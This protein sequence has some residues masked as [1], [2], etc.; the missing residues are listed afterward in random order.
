MTHLHP[1][2]TN[3]LANST[4]PMPTLEGVEDVKT[5]S[6]GAFPKVEDT[7]VSFFLGTVSD[8]SL[9]DRPVHIEQSDLFQQLAKANNTETISTIF[10]EIE[11]LCLMASKQKDSAYDEFSFFSRVFA[12][13]IKTASQKTKAFLSIQDFQRMSQLFP[14]NKLFQTMIGLYYTGVIHNSIDVNCFCTEQPPLLRLKMHQ[15]FVPTAQDVVDIAKALQSHKTLKKLDIHRKQIGS[16]GISVIAQALSNPRQQNT[17]LTSLNLSSN[18]GRQRSHE[19]DSM[20]ELVYVIKKNKT[21]TKLDL[22]GNQINSKTMDALV[23]ALKKNKTLK[24]LILAQNDINR[25]KSDDIFSNGFSPSF[26][27]ALSSHPTLTELN[28]S[29]NRM[30]Y[31][32][33]QAIATIMK[34][35]K[36]LIR[37][38]LGINQAGNDGAKKIAKALKQNST[39]TSLTLKWNRIGAEGIKAIAEALKY[40]ETL[41]ELD[42]EDN[43][44]GV[45]GSK[46]LAEALT[47]NKTLKHINL[48]KSL[49]GIEG[50]KAL[51]EALTQNTTLISL[52]LDY[53]EIQAEGSQAIAE[54]LTHNKTL[55]NFSFRY[56][57]LRTEGA[58]AMAEAISHNTTLRTLDLS[59]NR[60]DTEGVGALALALTRNTTLVD[61]TFGDSPIAQPERVI[62][63]LQQAEV[64]VPGRKITALGI[65]FH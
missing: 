18:R 20:F 2:K 39:I 12:P 65:A 10:R 27:K 50:A 4:T 28:L 5:Q 41:I 38:D 43:P 54:A 31:L 49:I 64:Q 7:Y 62:G 60:F 19:L 63:T 61:F 36:K 55:L 34:T 21:L 40:N 9:M 58:K 29:V 13:M 37:L 42:L 6:E 3:P 1:F 32:E 22:S 15:D 46:A 53:N 45:E 47:H 23:K 25:E 56:N 17:T 51:A 14:Q 26:I 48:G 59:L 16:A 33:M 52:N 57:E 30:A 11:D 8:A 44:I 24:K 35:N